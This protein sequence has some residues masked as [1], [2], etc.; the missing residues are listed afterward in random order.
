MKYRR[1]RE[2]TL[3]DFLD[4]QCIGRPCWAAGMYQHRSPLSCG[5]SRNTGSP[6]SPCCLNRAYRGCPMPDGKLPDFV[7]ELA[8]ERKAEGWKPV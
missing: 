8:K 6:D 2:K 4:A 3:Y 5:G 7:P 1:I